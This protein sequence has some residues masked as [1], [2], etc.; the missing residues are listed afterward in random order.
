MT[1]D[2]NVSYWPPYVREIAASSLVVFRVH[3]RFTFFF[4]LLMTTSGPYIMRL[5]NHQFYTP[6]SV[7]VLLGST[8]FLPTSAS[9]NCSLGLVMVSILYGWTNAVRARASLSAVARASSRAFTLVSPF[10]STT[11]APRGGRAIRPENTIFLTTLRLIEDSRD[12]V[13]LL[14]ESRNINS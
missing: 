7:R 8:L 11:I 10:A 6:R 1:S 5:T 3:P 12:L 2:P 13:Y 4:L 14:H 9:L